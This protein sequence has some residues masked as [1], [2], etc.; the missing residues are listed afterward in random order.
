M[1]KWL[2]VMLVAS[3]VFILF[4]IPWHII[5]NTYH[6]NH[7]VKATATVIRFTYNSKQRF[8]VLQY[9]DRQGGVHE[10]R[11]VEGFYGISNLYA[12]KLGDKFTAYYDKDNPSNSDISYGV[13]DNVPWYPAFF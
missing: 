11:G 5:I 8:P 9:T 4:T 3:L 10:T 2:R 1:K 12:P 13:W 6:R 7:S